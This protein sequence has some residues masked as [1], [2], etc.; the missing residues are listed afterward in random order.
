MGQVHVGDAAA[1]AQ[2]TVADREDVGERLSDHRLVRGDGGHGG[3][4]TLVGHEAGNTG[5]LVVGGRVHPVGEGRAERGAEEAEE[6]QSGNPQESVHG[7]IPFESN[8][9]EN[10]MKNTG[11][12]FLNKNTG[13]RPLSLTSGAVSE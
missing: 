3:P 1:G 12:E 7:R 8:H 4:V 6:E 9:P 10:Q 5:Y 11:L 13:R 2:R